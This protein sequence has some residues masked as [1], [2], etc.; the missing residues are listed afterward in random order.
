MKSKTL[1]AIGAS[2]GGLEALQDFLSH[3][4]AEISNTA[5]IVAQ[6]LSP[7]HKSM[8]VQLLSRETKLNVIEATQ[9]STLLAGT[10]YI[11]PPDCEILVTNGIVELR[12]PSASN[13]PKP[14]V[15]ILLESLG[16]NTEYNLIGVI[17]SGTGSDGAMG[18]RALKAAG[19]LIMVQDPATAK[20]DGMPLAS[21]DTGVVD[22]IAHP[23]KMG[24]EIK[25][26]LNNPQW[27]KELFPD[28]AAFQGTSLQHIFKLL[29]N[30]SG[31]DF[32]N[33]KPTTICRR[34]NKRLLK[35]HLDSIDDYLQFIQNEPQE[36]DELFNMILIGVT[37]FFRDPEAF[38]AL[39]TYLLALIASKKEKES[40]RIWVAGCATGEEPYSIAILLTQLLGDRKFKYNIQIFATD[41]DE[42]AIAIA[43]RGI[44]PESSLELVDKHIIQ[45]YFIQKGQ[46]FELNKTIR[47]MVLFSRH[48]LTSNP[49]FLRLDLIS[50]RNLLIYFG[51]ELQKQIMP[52]F[53]YALLPEKYLFLGK[54]ETIGEFQDLFATLNTK[55]KI[56]QRKIGN[57]LSSVRFSGLRAQKQIQLLPQQPMGKTES[58]PNTLKELVK[59]TFYSSFEHPYVVVNEQFDIQETVGDVRLYLSFPSGSMTINLLKYVHPDLLI[60]LRSLLV[61]AFKSNEHGTGKTKQLTVFGQLHYVKLTVKPVAGNALLPDWA[62]VI[63]EA[64]TN[65][66]LAI[67]PSD[68]AISEDVQSRM[69]QLE[70]ELAAT[71]EHLQSYIEEIET[72]NEEL[73]SLNEEMQSTNEELQSSNEELETNNEELQSTNEE[74]QIAYNELKV[75]NEELERK[76]RE[77][78]KANA[79]FTALFDNAQQG[80]ILLENNFTIR[81][82]NGKAQE[83]FAAIGINH[84]HENRN[85]LEIIP[86]QL[87]ADFLPFLRNA[88]VSKDVQKQLFTIHENG[89]TIYMEFCCTPVSSTNSTTSE[90]QF[91]NIGLIDFTEL[92]ERENTIFKKDE[93]LVSLLE[94]NTTYLVRTDMTGIYTYVNEAFCNKFGLTKQELIGSHFITT[95]HE[96]DLGHCEH[97]V[98][99]LFANPGSVQTVEMRKPNPVGGYFTT[100]WE[101]VAIRNKQGEVI[102][103]QCMGRD[104]TD[105]RKAQKQLL[106]E[107]DQ[108]EMVIRS[109]R[110]G[111]WDWDVTTG[112]IEFNQQW[113]KLLGYTKLEQF[114]NFEEWKELL[115]PADRERVLFQLQRCL[116]GH[117]LF[118]TIEHR[119]KAKSGEWKWLIA[120]GK[121][122]EKDDLGKATR[123][124]G[125]HQDITPLKSA[126]ENALLIESR[127]SA[128]LQ[129]MQEGV[130]VQNLEGAIVSCNPSAERILGLSFQQMIGKTSVDSTWRTI[131]EDGQPFPGEEHPAMMTIKT[132]N[133]QKN[134]VMGVYKPDGCL[135][136]IEVNSLMLHQPETGRPEAVYAIFH[137]ITTTVE[138]QKALGSVNNDLIQ[139]QSI[140][141]K[142]VEEL[143]TAQLSIQ[144]NERRLS[145]L[146]NGLPVAVYTID[147][148]GYLNFY[149]QAAMELWGREPVLFSDK[150]TGAHKLLSPVGEEISVHNCPLLQLIQ[151]KT[152][153]ITYEGVLET[154]TGELVSFLAHA[155]AIHDSQQQM[156]GA[157][158]VLVDITE[159]KNAER[160]KQLLLDRFETIA[161]QVPGM[162]YE[163]GQTELGN[164]SWISYTNKGV[165]DI[166]GVS[167]DAAKED[168][169]QLFAKI[170]P[171]DLPNVLVSIQESARQVSLWKCE[172]RIMKSKDS[173]IWIKG[174]A[175]PQRSADGTLVWRGFMHDVTEQKQMDLELQ[176]LSLIA[177]KTSN[178][179]VIT[180]ANGCIT[181]VND[182]FTR[183][184]GYKIEEVI[185]K[186]PGSV[187]QCENTNPDSVAL[188]RENIAKQ[189]GFTIEIL[190]RSKNGQDYWVEMEVQPLFHN[191]TLTGFMAIETDT[192]ERKSK[193]EEQKRLIT[194][195]THTIEDLT[196]FSYIVSHN[197][198]SPLTNIL[199][200]TNQLL[201]VE[202][203]GRPRTMIELLKTSAEK[204]DQVIFDLN[205]L[206]TLKNDKLEY[207]SINLNEVLAE[208]KQLLAQ[209]IEEVNAT[210]EADF[211][212]I[213][214]LFSVKSYI[215]SIFYN[216]INNAI[217]YAKKEVPLV[218]TIQA[219][220][221]DNQLHLSFRDN[222]IGI[223]LKNAK[224]KLFGLY[225]RFNITK[226]GKGIGLYLTKS[227]VK[228]L[229]GNISVE[230][231][232]HEGTTFYV[233]LPL[234]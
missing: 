138:A 22:V 15:D 39:C 129:S 148:E 157:M 149:N 218:L 213:P 101:F 24:E 220:I 130:V 207:Q 99:N 1:I 59:E 159:R 153:E 172:A 40:I 68:S 203:E 49:P 223:D 165:A 189:I 170:H 167:P 62:I 51:A 187:L 94:S 43:R 228:A 139:S 37:N 52:I 205:D 95:V 14:S 219:H 29:S 216:L 5:I 6:H 136:W 211:T 195:L 67:T 97:A 32:G 66:D 93:M 11:T 208:T 63:F 72:S 21:I 125:I 84:A 55:N 171:D 88:I 19:G 71:K 122:L 131:R 86:E 137:D 47:S 65:H 117:E 128:I 180:D 3:L 20:Y 230:S 151:E 133:P 158:N 34:I 179:V 33:Y 41:I 140:L 169:S 210:I 193:A 204:L 76:E 108:L 90:L 100:I 156:V 163:Y 50:C 4:P 18:V 74:I 105:E 80:N 111:T 145:E 75:A 69:I 110:L 127:N 227:N 120:S 58:R 98:G 200:L 150:W 176:K 232:L 123:I 191:E 12:K 73:Q 135:T 23:A 166:F 82:I 46:Y 38:E 190:N 168:V 85:I 121:V 36:L 112:H 102:E 77:L 115:H 229:G 161:D 146:L 212:T 141:S 178:A 126:E 152:L 9:Q 17:L 154:P 114:T 202:L 198:R 25:E 92:Y 215:A 224:Q 234:K 164:K 106:E 64:V 56:F 160:E 57:S 185:G 155:S 103:V 124:I 184:S 226:E 27:I 60:E 134:V 118:Y 113:L 194:Q 16:Q 132:G 162:L 209:Q 87:V 35:L 13:G 89:K 104:I 214:E 79:L 42:K 181:W 186:K 182:G 83:L 28:M 174:I 44:Y 30:R 31:T 201:K 48:D 53:H 222:G 54:S 192:T 206:L 109:G 116:D 10:V 96:G 199:G 221:M 8:L 142:H 2:A 196:Q 70:Q 78:N 143:K 26:F 175:S 177:E 45:A 81:L 144:D 147:S 217:K 91:F 107:R 231:T 119:K 233:V 183:I 197:L 61:G 225:Q 7:T 188:F 173:C